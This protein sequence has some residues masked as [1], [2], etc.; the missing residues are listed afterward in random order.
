MGAGSPPMKW[1]ARFILRYA[2]WVALVGTLLAVVGGY[3][4][5]Q[6]YK[7][8]RTDVEELLPQDARSVIDLAEVTKRLESIDNLAILIFSENGDAA[9]RFQVDLARE[10]EKIP[11]SV[12]SSVEYRIDK[13]LQFF[14]ERQSLYMD[15]ADLEKI[16]DYIEQRLQYEKEL[17]NPLNIFSEQDI[18]EPQLDF[19]ALRSKYNN[20]TSAY[21]RFPGG[22]YATPD[23]KKRVVLAYL[24]GKTS[25]IETVKALKHEAAAA[26]E[27]L[28]PASYAPDLQ[29]KWTGGV[30][31]TL[32]EH[33]ALI[34]DLELSTIIVALIVTFAL[35]FY[36]RSFM[37]T[38]AL[39]ASLF[40]GTLWTFGI[41]Y[42]VVGYLN[43]NSAFMGSIVLGNGI[44][45]GIIMLARY[46]EERRAGHGNTRSCQQ[47]MVH[48]A[49]ATWTAAAAAGLSYGSLMLTGFR[50]FRQFGTI[51]LLGMLLCWI[52]AFTVLPAYLTVLE[53][54]VRLV[55]P[56]AKAPKAYAAD[57]LARFISRFARP[58]WI[59]S[60][61]LTIAS[62]ATFVRYDDSILE[63]NLS[64]LRNKESMERGS[65]YL[66]KY[67]DEIFQRYLSPL[68]ILPRERTDA[69]RIAEI[70]RDRKE[71]EG[72]GSLIANVQTLDDFLPPEQREKLETL[73]EIR[74]LLP[75]RLVARLGKSDQDKVAELLRTQGLKPVRQG[76]LPDLV[77]RKFTEKDGS[78]GK[79]VLVEPPLNNVTW[80][81]KA[82]LEFIHSLRDTADSVSP[83]TP[84]AGATAITADMF[85]AIARDGPRATLFA[86]LSV[87][88]L[89]VFL[90]RHVQTV[91]LCL[92]ALGLGV[93][94]LAGFIL[95]FGYKINFLNFIALPITFGIG[96]D[97]GV[98]M[99]QRYREDSK[100]NILHVIRTTG[101]AVALCS[102]TTMVGYLSLLI[103]GNQGFVSFGRLAVIGEVTC[104]IAALVSLP[105]YL[106]LRS[107]RKG[108][109]GALAQ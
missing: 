24:P 82:L 44:N 27:R 64:K 62:L 92:F 20:K 37:A 86:F 106:M 77:L 85:E 63:T 98:N 87:V 18:P 75:R 32:E 66:S 36:Y 73:K 88:L 50:G 107:R 12:L 14:R 29:I 34:A 102:F 40:V 31:D 71:A 19:E 41:S 89:V 83:G 45:F 1:F 94:W 96:I 95:G 17:Y 80:D 56:G 51:G 4:S 22:L 69:R 55:P 99:F 16:R 105:A 100:A 8:L 67:V 48:T 79:M 33:E 39:A 7:N 26:V 90:F 15:L 58:I 60:L 42:F 46:L 61:I 93:T 104:S 6:L 2:G 108:Q 11:R 53:R 91:A 9:R 25:S 81:G 84:I 103:A 101:G 54:L 97:Y 49:T 47:A 65:A 35:L 13:E 78:I 28:K 72:P 38:I 43:A 21:S 76:T 5:V 3:Y 70:L 23:G 59:G 57:L 52:S 74:D 68:V 30:Q 10:L 109:P